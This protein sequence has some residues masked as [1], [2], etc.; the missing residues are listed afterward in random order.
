MELHD[1]MNKF[2]HQKLFDSLNEVASQDELAEKGYQAWLEMGWSTEADARDFKSVG[3]RQ[4]FIQ[5][6]KDSELRR[7]QRMGKGTWQPAYKQFVQTL[8]E[9]SPP[10]VGTFA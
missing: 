3:E 10:Q 7:V 6:C 1:D 9:Q 5:S 4:I 8:A 2:V